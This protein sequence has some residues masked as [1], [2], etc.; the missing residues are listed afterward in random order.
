MIL[1]VNSIKQTNTKANFKGFPDED[2]GILELVFS[3]KTRNDYL[4][5]RITSM[6]Y[7][8][9][10]LKK[11]KIQQWLSLGSEA[12]MNASKSLKGICVAYALRFSGYFY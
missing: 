1:A 11:Y 12:T 6:P 8:K 4:P 5:S 9:M 2:P 7:Y 10:M 3:R